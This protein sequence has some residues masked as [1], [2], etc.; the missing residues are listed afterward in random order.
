M[1]NKESR[2]M[3]A[4]NSE[5]VEESGCSRDTR[6]DALGLGELD[7]ILRS[8]RIWNASGVCNLITA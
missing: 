5:R 8:S 4:P 3:R 2:D 7:W 6:W 1:R